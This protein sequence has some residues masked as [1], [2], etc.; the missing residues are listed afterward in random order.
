MKTKTLLME[1]IE[2]EN[3]Y[4]ETLE[5][6]SKEYNESFDRL[7]KLLEQLS[8][9]EQQEMEALEKENQAKIDKKDRFIRNVM[10]GVKIG[11]SI[12][13]PVVGLVGITAAEKDISFTGALREYTK[14]F[15]PK[16]N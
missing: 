9:L 12:V 4:L 5:V 16:K 3:A 6:G 14:F 7:G 15:L 11:A 1:R 13:L 2:N 8:K 10:E